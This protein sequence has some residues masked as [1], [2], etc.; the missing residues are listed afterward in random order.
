[1]DTK[2]IVTISISSLAFLLSLMA[3]M[4]SLVRSK[5]EKQRA[6]KKE[7][8]DILGK[9]VSTSLEN[10]KLYRESAEKD[11]GYYQAISSV[12]NQQN[13][14]LLQ[15]ATYLMDEVPGLVTAVEY[16]TV[17]AANANAG[18]LISAEIFYKRAIDVSPN[19]FY[20]S[21]AIRSY[22]GHLFAQHRFEEARENFRKAISLLT[23]S[24][25]QIRY[26]NG[27]TYQMWGWNEL[28]NAASPR[29]AEDLFESAANEFGGIDNEAFRRQ[30]LIGLQAAKL[31]PSTSDP[32]P[33]PTAPT[34]AAAEPNP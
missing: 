13:V 19:V 2:D 28:N 25:N 31:L 24:D 20:R 30:A 15:Q 34:F 16:N 1:M 27:L 9:I 23:G 3:T 4:V 21:L 6:I 8:T 26:T 32:A 22:G 7:I 18:D 12:L 14:F 33:Q 10:A 29:R 17:A 5:Y 11:P